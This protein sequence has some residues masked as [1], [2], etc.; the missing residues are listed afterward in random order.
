VIASIAFRKALSQ[1]TTD[2]KNNRSKDWSSFL[3]VQINHLLRIPDFGI[4]PKGVGGN[5]Y[6]INAMQTHDG[7][8]WRMIIH[9]NP[10][11]EAYGIYAGGQEG[12]PGSK[13]YD[14]FIKPWS[15]NKYFKLWMMKEDEANDKRVIL[16]SVFS[17]AAK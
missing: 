14:N 7:P 10:E 4:K 17:P 11:N 12:N 13:N 5:K 1:F 8:G 2:A 6:C 16:K 9:L 15:E 3:D